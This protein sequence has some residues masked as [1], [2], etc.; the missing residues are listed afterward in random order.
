M[1]VVAARVVHERGK[2]VRIRR[3]AFQSFGD[4]IGGP[5]LL[6]LDNQP[7]SD[8]WRGGFESISRSQADSDSKVAQQSR[9]LFAAHGIAALSVGFPGR[10]KS[11]GSHWSD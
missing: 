8:G 11:S 3:K 10:L 1:A 7:I 2:I 5:P 4:G 9:N 6:T